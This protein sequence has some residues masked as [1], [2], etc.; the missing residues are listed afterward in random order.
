MSVR[1]QLRSVA[2]DKGLGFRKSDNNNK[3]HKNTS[4]RT[5]F[6]AIGDP[7]GSKYSRRADMG[8]VNDEVEN[9]ALMTLMGGD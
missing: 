3:K 2:Y 6:V 4:Q 1:S 8:V 5:T 9:G 7:C